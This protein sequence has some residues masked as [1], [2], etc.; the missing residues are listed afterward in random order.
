[1][2]LRITQQSEDVVVEGEGSPIRVTQQSEDVVITD[3]G[4]GRVSQEGVHVIAS[5]D[6]KLDVSQ[7][8]LLAIAKH[9]TKVQISQI[10]IYV[11]VPIL[12]QQIITYSDRYPVF[13]LWVVDENDDFVADLTQYLVSA[14][15]DFTEELKSATAVMQLD[16][17]DGLFDQTVDGALS[18]YAAQRVIFNFKKGFRDPVTNDVTLYPAF[19][20]RIR[21][22]SLGYS[23]KGTEVINITLFDN[24]GDIVKQKIIS[25]EYVNW[26]AVNIGYDLL[27]TYGKILPSK[28]L[29]DSS[30][31]YVFPDVQFPEYFVADA[32]QALFDPILYSVRTDYSGNI[33]AVPKIGT[34]VGGVGY[35][36]YPDQ[37]TEP[38]SGDI[39]KVLSDGTTIQDVQIESTS[40][41]YTNQVHA[42][43]KATDDIIVIGP[44]QMLFYEEDSS[45]TANDSK[46]F[47]K[48]YGGSPGATNL[49]L[50]KD[51]YIDFS[52]STN[53]QLD[54]APRHIHIDALGDYRVYNEDPHWVGGIQ[55]LA[56]TS[57]FITYRI[58]GVQFS[59]GGGLSVRH[60]G[61]Y[62]FSLIAYGKPVSSNANYINKY[63]DYNVHTV[64]HEDVTSRNIYSDQITY[65]VLNYPMAM[66]VP[67]TAYIN[68]VAVGTNAADNSE[69]TSVFKVRYQ[70]GQI[71]FTNPLYKDWYAD[72]HYTGGTTSSNSVSWILDALTLPA[73]AAVY[74][75]ARIND[76]HY[77]ITGL[78]AGIGYT[79]RLHF[80]DPV[81]NGSKQRI[82]TVYANG[83]PIVTDLDLWDTVKSSTRPYIEEVTG[84]SSDL[85]GN[86][87]LFIGIHDPSTG[88]LDH[89]HNP[90]DPDYISTAVGP[91]L[92]CGIELFNASTPG[93]EIFT[94]NSGGTDIL[95]P[96][97]SV[98]VDYGYSPEQVSWGIQSMDIN[99]P[100]ITTDEQ[101][102]QTGTYWVNRSAWQRW[103]MNVILASEPIVYCG[104]LIKFF[105]PKKNTDYVMYVS[106]IT[107]L[108][109]RPDPNQPNDDSN[110][111]MDTYAGFLI[112]KKN[113]LS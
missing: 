35:L 6:A 101:L 55:V 51:V 94:N 77:I 100:L 109:E 44:E 14:K 13:R 46:V 10:G 78:Q 75:T 22:T 70:D 113:R 108:S 47:Q 15:L 34:S 104:D 17:T 61:G 98:W 33:V 52:Y 38:S 84:V 95:A 12:H 99:N 30:I 39:I 82:F 106:K 111:D 93:P 11:L 74:S 87:D 59:S 41:E 57:T 56:I 32:L 9:D 23:R 80:A 102:I 79:I 65:Q 50:A 28:V 2:A 85:S 89:I 16:N 90:S 67:V 107:R 86:I 58:Y 8:G 71:V 76:S 18:E 19:W 97:P 54:T 103:P 26:Q 1:M 91:A 72:S 88:L 68:G 31:D 49:Q 63:I 3:Q 62:D 60:H 40:M 21:N 96:K 92:I 4:T 5:P 53:H 24:L 81:S 29:L 83:S 110:P 36:G 69:L 112:Y 42:M 45:I 25:P 66:S 27:T 7:Q 105:F 43:G 37:L 20:G 48:F 73:P 64:T